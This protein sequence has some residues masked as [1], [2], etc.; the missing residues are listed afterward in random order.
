MCNCVLELFCSTTEKLEVKAPLCKLHLA[1]KVSIW[2][3]WVSRNWYFCGYVNFNWHCMCIPLLVDLVCEV[4]KYSQQKGIDNVQ[5][6]SNISEIYL[7]PNHSLHLICFL[8]SLTV[9]SHHSKKNPFCSSL[10][11]SLL[12][13][14][15]SCSS[16]FLAIHTDPLLHPSNNIFHLCI[17]LW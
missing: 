15:T 12:V 11:H 7:S 6:C 1:T 2:L 17:K 5:L 4:L 14:A 3:K 9:F 16:G 13:T 8:H 10:R